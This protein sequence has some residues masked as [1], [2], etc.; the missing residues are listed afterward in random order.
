MLYNLFFLHGISLFFYL[1]F[2][3]LKIEHVVL[4]NLSFNFMRSVICGSIALYSY[5]NYSKIFDDKCL[6]NDK[7]KNQLVLFH[8][9]FLHYFIY[10]LFVM[11][12]QVFVKINKSIR[13][14]LLMHHLLAI[15]ILTYI[16]RNEMYNITLL[17]GLSEGMSFVSGFKLLSN[18]LGLKKYSNI[19]IRVRVGYLFFIRMLFLW[20]SLLYF[21]YQITN[22]CEKFKKEKNIQLV[23]FF[24]GVIVMNEIKWIRS[25]LKELNRI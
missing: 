18:K 1:L 2:D 17:I 25:G 14:D 11:M 4:G 3:Q 22:E 6:E 7:F 16:S 9:R 8:D 19:C 24:I 21:Y 12:Y 20:P 15:F 10:D 13:I 5:Q 23:C